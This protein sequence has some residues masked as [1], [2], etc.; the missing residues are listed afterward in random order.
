MSFLRIDSLVA[1][2]DDE[3]DDGLDLEGLVVRILVVWP[4]ML[5]LFFISF[6]KKE[7]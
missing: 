6:R 7:K 4:M 1:A 3:T 2:I 5:V